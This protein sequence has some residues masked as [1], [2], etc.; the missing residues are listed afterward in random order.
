MSH[1]APIYLQLDQKVI[2]TN[3]KEYNYG[4]RVLFESEECLQNYADHPAHLDFKKAAGGAESI[5]CLDWFTS[6]P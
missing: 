6:S 5:V 4:L 1:S 3:I 2:K